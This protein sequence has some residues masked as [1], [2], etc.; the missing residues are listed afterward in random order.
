MTDDISQQGRNRPFPEVASEIF[1]S[2]FEQSVVIPALLAQP[3]RSDEEIRADTVARWHASKPEVDLFH[4]K[5]EAITGDL[6]QIV[7]LHEW[8][9]GHSQ[10]CAGCPIDQMGDNDWP[11]PTIE[12]IC[13]L[14]DIDIP[15]DLW[16]HAIYPQ[17]PPRV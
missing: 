9:H 10:E 11:C 16:I 12:R 7:G 13:E 5:L 1:A 6:G 15:K 17:E 4:K 14:R 3:Q 8:Q 2:V